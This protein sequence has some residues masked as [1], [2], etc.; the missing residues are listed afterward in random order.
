VIPRRYLVPLVL[1]LPVLVVAFAVLAGAALLAQG[2]G[3]QSGFR[4]LL[5]AALSA[6]MLLA[7]DALLLLAA[8]GIKAVQDEEER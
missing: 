4:G 8:L 3:D 6:L 5:W 1:A 7:I 2:L